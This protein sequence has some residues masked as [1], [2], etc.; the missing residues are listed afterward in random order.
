MY[1][2]ND[3]QKDFH[4]FQTVKYI[5]DRKTDKEQKKVLSVRTMFIIYFKI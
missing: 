3:A 5:K 2:C 4:T 1:G